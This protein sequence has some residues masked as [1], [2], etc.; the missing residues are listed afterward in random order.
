MNKIVRRN[1][2]FVFI[3]HSFF[4]EFRL[5]IIDYALL[6]DIIRCKKIYIG[7]LIK[8]FEMKEKNFHKKVFHKKLKL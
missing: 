7:I 8:Y 5:Y 2:K 1:Y 4:N 3:G 6:V